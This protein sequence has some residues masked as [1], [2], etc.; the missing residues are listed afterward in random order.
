MNTI[1][2]DQRWICDHI[3][4]VFVFLLRIKAIITSSQWFIIRKGLCRNMLNYYI[5]A[6]C[7]I[8]LISNTIIPVV[9]SCSNERVY[10]HDN[11]LT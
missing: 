1:L 2:L 10:T 7:E 4:V 3:S 9:S 5:M 11:T 8:F 6:L